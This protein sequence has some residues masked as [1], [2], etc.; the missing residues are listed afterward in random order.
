MAFRK[1]NY[2]QSNSYNIGD[3]K[4][5]VKIQ[6]RYESPNN[7]ENLGVIN[8]F[9][10]IF[11]VNCF[12]KTLK[13]DTIAY[14]EDGY[15]LTPNIKSIKN[16]EMVIP[17]REGIDDECFVVFN[18]IRYKIIDVQ[19]VDNMGIFLKCSLMTLGNTNLKGSEEI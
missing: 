8:K 9:Y 5:S 17:Y 12:W 18:N 14:D 10:T 3:M 11:E 13:F 2:A 7:T 15:S 16:A 1:S 6:K 4:Y 19:N